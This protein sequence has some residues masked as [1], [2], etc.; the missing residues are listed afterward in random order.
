M[1]HGRARARTPD[2]RCASGVVST[3]AR[4]RRAGKRRDQPIQIRRGVEDEETQLRV[5]RRAD[6]ERPVLESHDAAEP[7]EAAARD[8]VH[9]RD[10]LFRTRP[11][12]TRSVRRR[13]AGPSR[14]AAR[15]TRAARRPDG[16]DQ[17]RLGP[18]GLH[19][20]R[21]VRS[22]FLHDQP[23]RTR[24]RDVDVERAGRRVAAG[25]GAVVQARRL[26][27]QLADQAAG[28][29]RE[30]MR[31]QLAVHQLERLRRRGV[32]WRADEIT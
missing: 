8:V 9:Q 30:P 13:R 28:A 27:R 23:E 1:V 21:H 14:R 7:R 11:T 31:Q 29:A 32:G 12:R 19:R 16:A 17:L 2:R 25:D 18:R 20:L 15:A 22:D 3:G 4:E 10:G 6:V 5:E 26:G 24:L